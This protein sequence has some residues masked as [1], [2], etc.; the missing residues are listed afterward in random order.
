MKIVVDNAIP[1]IQGVFEP[2]F[3]VVYLPG[4][5]IVNSAVIDA[6]ALVVRTRTICNAQLLEGTAVKMIATATIGTDHI[7]L[8]YCKNAGITV[9]NA[10]GCNAGGVM[11]YV[12]TALYGVA[13]KKGIQLPC[14]VKS[15]DDL[16]CSRVSTDTA[17]V[18]RLGVIGVGNVGTRVANMGEYMGFEVLRCDPAKEREQTLAFN[19]GNMHLKDFK[20]FYSLEYVLEN[21][22]IITLHTDLNPTSRGMAG[23]EFFRKMKDGAI[24]INSSR[25][26]VVQDEALLA[27]CGKLQGLI[28]D[29]WNGEP[30]LNIALMEK[31]DI[32]TPHIAGY[33][34]EGKVNG[35][36]MSVKSIARHFGIEE[37]KEFSIV[38]QE[39]NNNF[40][41]KN[42]LDLNEISGYFNGIFPIFEH[43]ADLKGNPGDFEKLRSNFKYRREFYVI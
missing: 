7:D 26:E 38:P 42:G 37:L 41:S 3:N 40:F 23:E 1:F 27:H 35:T 32:A 21:S 43:C 13:Q 12:F 14:G 6:D 5:E 18:P 10:A 28:L 36:V 34:Y 22:D 39:K 25:G 2:Y 30:N 11:Q 24:F 16:H 19:A 17:V 33:S 8:E 4:K 9:S 20:P 15:C 31:A 29:V